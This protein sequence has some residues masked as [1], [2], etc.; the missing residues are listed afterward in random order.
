[1]GRTRYAG[2]MITRLAALFLALSPL[3]FL[4]CLL[5]PGCGGSVPA[6]SSV[7]DQLDRAET[8]LLL[9]GVPDALEISSGG[10][11][12]GGGSGGLGGLQA[13]Y[14]LSWI[15]NFK[16]AKSLKTISIGLVAAIDNILATAGAVEVGRGGGNPSM[17]VGDDFDVVTRINQNWEYELGGMSGHIMLYAFPT[18]EDYNDYEVVLYVVEYTN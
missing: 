8:S 14:D 11:S 6:Q 1:M 13:A 9:A 4:F 10:G 16:S 5:L 7:L 3:S 18:K 17:R 12:G 2:A 15:A